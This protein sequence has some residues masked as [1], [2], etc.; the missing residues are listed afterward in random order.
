MGTNEPL[1]A[2]SW[3]MSADFPVATGGDVVMG[4]AGFPPLQR[5]KPAT[6]G[7]RGPGDI[8]GESPPPSGDGIRRRPSLSAPLS[9]DVAGVSSAPQ[10]RRWRLGLFSNESAFYRYVSFEPKRQRNA[11]CLRLHFE[12]PNVRHAFTF[13]LWEPKDTTQVYVRVLEVRTYQTR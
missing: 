6:P 13:P 8:C 7:N 9:S 5:R 4:R 2:Q 12:Y 3:A 10:R 1:E 11:T